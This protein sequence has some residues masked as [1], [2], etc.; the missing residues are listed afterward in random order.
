[1][2]AVKVMDAKGLVCFCWTEPRAWERCCDMEE[3]EVQWIG[4]DGFDQDNPKK[5]KCPSRGW[6]CRSYFEHAFRELDFDEEIKD[7]KSSYWFCSLGCAVNQIPAQLKSK[8][9][10]QLSD[11]EDW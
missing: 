3:D 7:K 10:T 2:T 11:D 4:C 5:S 9:R 1:M 6:V 8:Y